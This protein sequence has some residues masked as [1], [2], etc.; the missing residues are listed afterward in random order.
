MSSIESKYD[1]HDL[2]LRERAGRLDRM[3]VSDWQA[4]FDLS[5]E[6]F[7]RQT[8][9]SGYV[10]DVLDTLSAAVPELPA[11]VLAAVKL[12][13]YHYL[14]RKLLREPLPD[15]H[16]ENAGVRQFIGYHT[17]EA[18]N[19]LVQDIGEILK[20]GLDPAELKRCLPL[21]MDTLSVM[22]TEMLADAPDPD[23]FFF[24]TY[25]RLWEGWIA[26]LTGGDSSCAE[27]LDR[28]LK[29]AGNRNLPFGTNE[30]NLLSA[31]SRMLFGLSRDSEAISLLARLA[32]KH[33]VDQARLFQYLNGLSRSQQWRRLALWLTDTGMK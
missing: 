12:N 32:E 1:D 6:P 25:I 14:L 26:P 33:P 15:A 31:Q 30:Y 29:A 23:H 13:A 3:S 7:D 18:A 27:E 19:G 5:S 20:E 10:S 8:R 21:L 28:L 24:Q 2:R 22:R 17:R 16:G 9:N 4:F 11:A